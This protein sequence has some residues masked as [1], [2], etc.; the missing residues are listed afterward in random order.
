MNTPPRWMMD[1]GM[2]PRRDLARKNLKRNGQKCADRRGD[3]V[4][5]REDENGCGDSIAV[6][7]D[8]ESSD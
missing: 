3:D 8:E 1:K 4:P 5:G 7:R 6:E 2:R